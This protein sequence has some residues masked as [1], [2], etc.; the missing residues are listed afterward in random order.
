MHLV[1]LY[2]YCRMMHGAYNV[3][4][5]I[6]SL[7]CYKT[8]RNT[9]RTAYRNVQTQMKT[10]NSAVDISNVA[11]LNTGKIFVV[12]S[13]PSRRTRELWTSWRSWHILRYK[14][15]SFLRMTVP[16][17]VRCWK[18]AN[19][20]RSDCLLEHTNIIIHPLIAKHNDNLPSSAHGAYKLYVIHN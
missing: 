19:N 7:C 14:K 11:K 4:Y 6:L 5:K 10:R 9:N 12:L 8:L 2:T 1:G 18:M 15:V 3:K 17:N 16:V 20:I 13:G